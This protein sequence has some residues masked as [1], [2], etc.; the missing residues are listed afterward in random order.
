[1]AVGEWSNPE[2]SSQEPFRD[3]SLIFTLRSERCDT[4][5]QSSGTSLRRSGR[6]RVVEKNY[7]LQDIQLSKSPPS[8]PVGRFGETG[9]RSL[10]PEPVKLVRSRARTPRVRAG[11]LDLAEAS[12]YGEAL[13]ARRRLVENTGL[14]P[15]TSWLQTMRSPS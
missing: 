14:E 9:P 1:M 5:R 10:S 12:P 13:E 6:L 3:S 4:F 2:A 11:C 8:R 7:R 15:V